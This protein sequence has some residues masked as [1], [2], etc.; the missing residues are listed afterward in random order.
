M[1]N[2]DNKKETLDNISLTDLIKTGK[3]E[4][5]PV[6]EKSPLQKMKEYKESHPGMIVNNDEITYDNEKKILKDSFDTER[7][8]SDF[9]GYMADMDR[10]IDAAQS[11]NIE[12]P[13][14]NEIETAAMID[15]L[16]RIAIASQKKIIPNLKRF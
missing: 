2:E 8:E 1:A 4:E 9:K 6:E 15:Q 13:P 10:L 11:V 3:A 5:A 14:Q 12:R 16:D 7:R